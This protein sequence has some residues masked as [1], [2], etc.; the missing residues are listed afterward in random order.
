MENAVFHWHS[1]QHESFLGLK[2]RLTTAPILAYPD[3]SIPFTLYTDTSGDSIGFNLTQVQ[4]GKKEPLF[5][6]EGTFQT[7]R[8]STPSQNEKH[9]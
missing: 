8:K 9:C 7:R 6:V 5:M 1:L 3:F 4:H 2:E